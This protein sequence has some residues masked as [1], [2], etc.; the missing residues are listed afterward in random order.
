MKRLFSASAIALL[1]AGCS[2]LGSY[3]P[4]YDSSASRSGPAAAPGFD[5][6]FTALRLG[7]NVR[8]EAL[9]RQ[10]L[11][12]SPND[13]YTLLSLGVAS[14]R[15][16]KTLDAQNY[17]RAAAEFGGSAP[18]G[19]TIGV[20]PT[21]GRNLNTIRDFALYNLAQ[22]DTAS[23]VYQPATVTTYEPLPAPVVYDTVTPYR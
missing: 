14:H 9:L 7:D 16:G 8:A 1:L 4:F 20:D 10:S 3:D 18:I 2:P 5:N 12:A 23:T 15:L 21:T 6:G 22:Y 17:Y 19:E 11:A 13:P